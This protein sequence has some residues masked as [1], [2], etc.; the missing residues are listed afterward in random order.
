MEKM[1]SM[2]KQMGNLFLIQMKT[3]KRSQMVILKMTN[4]I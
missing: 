4:K 3:I 1:D 2:Y